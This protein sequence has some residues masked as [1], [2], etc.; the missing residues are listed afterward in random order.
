MVIVLTP[1]DEHFA[2]TQLFLHVRDHQIPVF[3]LEQSG[4]RVSKWLGDVITGGR[5]QRNIDLQTFG[6]GGLRKTL[7]SEVRENI[8]QPDSDLATLHDIRGRS[9]IKIED[10][11]AWTQDVPG[12]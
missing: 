7:Q 2:D 3:I 4:E 1:V 11:A 12:Q 10:H 5:I 8:L 9:R 6:A